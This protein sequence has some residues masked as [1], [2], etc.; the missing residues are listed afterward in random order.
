MAGRRISRASWRLAIAIAA[1]LA[2][3]GTGCQRVEEKSPTPSGGSA[4][5]ER[6]AFVGATTCTTCHPTQ[7]Q[8]FMGSH[9]ARA[10]Q[11]A[12][13]TTVLG[14]FNNARF[15]HGG[16]TSTFFKQD[17][18][19]LVRTEGADGKP[20]EFEIAYTFG[21]EPLQQYLVPV[22]GGRLQPLG[23]A[24]DSR[25]RA[26]GGQRWFS[27]YPEKLR[28]H[29]PLHW[30]GRDQTWNYQ[31]AECHSTDLQKNYD[32]AANTY[33]TRWSEIN[34]SCE[35]CHGPGSAH[36]AWARS[37]PPGSPRPAGDLAGL[38][39]SLRRGAGAW[40]MKDPG[41]GIA[42][43]VGPA[44]THAELD[45]CAR[46]HA[47]RRPIVDP[48]PHGR[49]FLDAAMP[50]LL[51]AGLYHADGQILGEVYEYGSV[52]Q[53]RMHRAGVTCS[54]CH[55]PHTLELR[56]PDN[57]V[58]AQCHL[59]ARFEVPAHHHHA[60]GSDGARCVSCHMP[61]RRYMVV[62]PRRDHSF[63]VP[64]PDLSVAIGTPNPCTECHKNRSA[65]WAAALVKTWYGR[66]REP[67]SHF[68]LALDAGRRGL[69][70][71]E[72]RLTALVIDAEQPAIARATALG[73]LREFLSAASLPAVEAGLRDDNPLVRAAALGTLEALPPERRVT[74]A[75][76]AL[77]DP[78]RVVRI[79]AA[80]ALA[81]IRGFAPDQQSELDRAIA[82]LIA[83]EMVSAERPET[84]LNLANLYSRLG[85]PAE[86]ESQL[87]SALRL[88]PRF[89]PALVNLADL[90]RG[91][92]RDADGEGLL[93]EALG[94]EPDSAE[95]IHALALLR[96]RQG[97]QAEAVRLLRR[98]ATLRP[99]TIR[100]A[101]VYAVAL[102]STGDPKGA[103]AVLEQAHRRRPA[104]RDVLAALVS[105][106][107]ERGDLQ[108][109]LRHAETLATLLPSDGLVQ[110]QRSE[111]AQ[112]VR[113]PSIP[114]GKD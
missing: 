22:S 77:R 61:Q 28:P 82:E 33:A 106:A 95:A 25:P 54:D 78:I 21:V 40:E 84:H 112:L 62:D 13:D 41:R 94:L 35:A 1:G 3:V 105:I 23:I 69:P 113:P 53:S 50:A 46:C 108:T 80:Q 37:R 109:A 4:P 107:R 81:G 29:D 70:D 87:R 73:L 34:V 103:I 20:G 65:S 56:A 24:W 76:P 31:C 30:T 12:S 104:N 111:L 52:L 79:A 68:A 14:D 5:V 101:Y 32:L 110:A 102:N 6:P 74:L 96:V 91:I 49:P 43:W 19:Y 89:V 86:A 48:Y 66:E 17:G 60:A 97:R 15:A 51:T 7:A 100:F 57:G 71:A 63:R 67:R 11:T 88:D 99:E 75:G 90:L 26:E 58:C 72:R 16:M 59:P 10:M 93:Q 38:V 92:G 83:S 27:L 64:R 55:D 47:R 85:R 2:L 39:V 114:R 44:R 42:Q 9:H 36:L 98:A 45:A 18:K 8:A